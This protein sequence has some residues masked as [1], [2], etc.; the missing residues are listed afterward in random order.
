MDDFVASIRD[1]PGFADSR[2]DRYAEVP[3]TRS[4]VFARQQQKFGLGA[5]AATIFD[6]AGVRPTRFLAR[7][8][9]SPSEWGRALGSNATPANPRRAGAPRE[10]EQS[11]AEDEGLPPTDPEARDAPEISSRLQLLLLDRALPSEPDGD[12]KSAASPDDALT[13]PLQVGPYG[14]SSAGMTPAVLVATDGSAVLVV[15]S[16]LSGGGVLC[17]STKAGGNAKLAPLSAADCGLSSRI[18][19][20]AAYCATDGSPLLLL[21][22]SNDSGPSALVAVDLSSLSVVWRHNL[23]D[24]CSGLGV[25][26]AGIIFSDF[27][28]NKLYVL[29]LLQP[30]S[31]AAAPPHATLTRVGLWGP[32]FI[33]CSG[34]TVFVCAFANEEVYGQRIGLLEQTGPATVSSNPK[35]RSIYSFTYIDGQFSSFTVVTAAGESLADRP[36]AVM[37]A[38]PGSGTPPCLVVGELGSSTL[39]VFALGGP[40]GPFFVGSI[41]LSGEGAALAGL[42]AHPSGDALL[43]VLE[44]PREG[45]GVQ[46]E[47]LRWLP[48]PSS[49][50]VPVD[51]D[52]GVLGQPS[53]FAAASQAAVPPLR[54]DAAPQMRRDTVAPPPMFA[55]VSAHGAAQPQQQ[56]ADAAVQRALTFLSP[57]P[58]SNS[59]LSE[60]ALRSRRKLQRLA[61][62]LGDSWT[63]GNA[64]SLSP[65]LRHSLPSHASDEVRSSLWLASV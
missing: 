50:F 1:L 32:T 11:V 55:G 42:A 54:L 18:S 45:T 10:T 28:A 20:A 13:P 51:S 53:A 19:C 12:S 9:E 60:A 31:G 40:D 21:A 65:L 35:S 3:V 44:P 58:I 23:R 17:F 16:S 59:D 29:R 25:C 52:A 56:V 27:T 61:S 24:G 47:S 37:N 14:A 41:S 22:D 36:L 5:A 62:G 63:V 33:T 46:V 2:E 43:A 57:P 7:S 38:R 26:G 39:L 15:P 6:P 4:A 34:S 48:W 30:G 8:P 64:F 49:D